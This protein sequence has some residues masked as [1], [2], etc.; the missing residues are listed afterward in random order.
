LL[1]Q[2]QRPDLLGHIARHLLKAARGRGM[3]PF[4][5]WHKLALAIWEPT[6]INPVFD[7]LNAAWKAAQVDGWPPPEVV[8]KLRRINEDAWARTR[9]LIHDP[10]RSPKPRA[11]RGPKDRKT[12]RSA[13]P[14][15]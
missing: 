12:E 3:D 15:A 14:S 7:F 5:A 6:L 10:S 1:E 2:S 8:M 4:T 11:A 9:G 13:I